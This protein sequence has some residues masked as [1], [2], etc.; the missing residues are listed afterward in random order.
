MLEILISSFLAVIIIGLVF[1]GVH[2]WLMER[3]A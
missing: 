3:D 2:D 1:V